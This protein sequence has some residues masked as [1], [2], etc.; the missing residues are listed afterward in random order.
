MPDNNPLIQILATYFHR[1][2]LKASLRNYLFIAII[3]LVN[4]VIF[5]RADSAAAVGGSAHLNIMM[6]SIAG[7]ISL[8]NLLWD[9]F[10]ELTAFEGRVLWPGYAPR[11]VAVFLALSLLLIAGWPDFLP[12]L[13]SHFSPQSR[14]F[15]AFVFVLLAV[16]SWAYLLL[17]AAIFSGH[18]LQWMS[19]LLGPNHAPAMAAGLVVLAAYICLIIHALR[20]KIR[21]PAVQRRRSLP[22]NIGAGMRLFMFISELVADPPT[23]FEI[24]ARSGLWNRAM[25]WSA[26]CS[27]VIVRGIPLYGLVFYLI[28]NLICLPFGA[29]SWSRLAPILFALVPV[30]P[31][32]GIPGVWLDYW[33]FLETEFLRPVDRAAMLREIALAIAINLFQAWAVLSAM[34][35]LALILNPGGAQT[36]A[37]LPALLAALLVQI[38]G[39]GASIWLLRY[40]IRELVHLPAVIIAI[41]IAD[42]IWFKYSPF[43]GSQGGVLLLAAGMAGVGLI[44]ASDAARRWPAT[45]L[46]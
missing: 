5:Q 40:R 10:R 27:G 29:F 30:L 2:V 21:T 20:G 31:A 15:N 17:L 14:G 13:G 44:L 23:R 11:Q 16:P 1:C 36:S 18:F 41:V 4:A 45:E 37:V 42:L 46:G 22:K 3:L 39:W 32:A 35:V 19:L 28:L 26:L 12:N 7:F 34:I 43:T 38:F 8:G 9:N 6:L 33:R 24:P 25:A